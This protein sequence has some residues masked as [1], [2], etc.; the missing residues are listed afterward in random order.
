ML[1]AL[2]GPIKAGGAALFA[3]GL[4][5]LL[6]NPPELSGADHSP[7]TPGEEGTDTGNP[8]AAGADEEG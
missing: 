4:L 1:D 2:R 6:L 3:V 5:L 8:D 7:G